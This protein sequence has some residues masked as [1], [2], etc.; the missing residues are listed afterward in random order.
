MG[1]SGTKYGPFQDIVFYSFYQLG[2]NVGRCAVGRHDFI[3]RLLLPIPRKAANQKSRPLGPPSPTTQ[4]LLLHCL[5]EALRST[6]FSCWSDFM[7]GKPSRA[8]R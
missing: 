6:S 4:A 2:M 1:L 8:T 5:P 3:H 7:P